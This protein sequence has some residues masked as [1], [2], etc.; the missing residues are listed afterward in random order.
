MS[1]RVEGRVL[2]WEWAWHV[3]PTLTAAHFLHSPTTAGTVHPPGPT[4]SSLNK[5]CFVVHPHTHALAQPGN[6]EASQKTT[7]K[8]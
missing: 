2:A 7:A 6:L 1:V 5:V 4:F 3:A 8:K